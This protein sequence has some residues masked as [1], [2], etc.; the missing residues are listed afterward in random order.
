[1]SR[2]HD[3]IDTSLSRNQLLKIIDLLP[4]NW[5]DLNYRFLPQACE[6]KVLGFELFIGYT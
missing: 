6:E 4:S 2:R 1:M 3:L 5:T